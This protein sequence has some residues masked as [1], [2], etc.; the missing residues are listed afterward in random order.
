MKKD[1]PIHKVEDI[2]IAISP[3]EETFDD[4]DSLWDVFILNLKDEPITCVL[5]NST[6]YLEDSKTTTLR[7][8]FEAIGPLSFMLIEPIQARLFDL[9]NEYWVSFMH[10]DYMYDKKYVFVRGSINS[11]HFTDIPFLG[12]KGVMI[13]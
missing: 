9:N 6:G 2:I 10:E 8:F 13:R 4:P 5:V 12:R 11:T 7:H 1:I 3:R